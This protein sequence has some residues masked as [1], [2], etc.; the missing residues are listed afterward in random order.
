ME[1]FEWFATTITGLEDLAAEEVEELTNIPAQPDVG[2]IFFRAGIEHALIVNYSSTLVNRVFLLLAR[3][4]IE[5]LD[6][7]YK[8]A[9]GLDYSW[10]IEPSQT[11]AVRAERHDKQLAFTSMDAAATIGRAIIENFKSSM[12][13]RL[14][15]NLDNPDLEFYCLLRGS[16]MFLGLDTTGQSLHR[17]Y[18]RVYAHRAGLQPTI[19]SAMI[20]ISKWR[21]NE[22]LLDPMCGGGTIPI[23]A[24]IRLKNIPCGLMRRE[25]RLEKLKF[26]DQSMV[27]ELRKKIED[28]IDRYATSEIVGSDASPKS[29]EGAR[30]NVE[31]ANVSDTVKLIIGDCLHLEDWLNWEPTHIITNP[32]YGIRVNIR[33][34]AEFYKRFI[35]SVGRAA[36]HS[37]LTVIVSKPRVF[38][39]I[40]EEKNYR[41]QSMREILYGRLRASIIS[42][43]R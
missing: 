41:I 1:Y 12:N 29:I 11:F 25:V 37:K 31:A 18:Y 2:K 39:K 9:K 22:S 42:A 30:R 4:K 26:V 21:K 32:P 35:D 8:V 27:R 10:I 15:V 13:I 7:V 40:L 20:K 28:K 43:E 14:K 24:A 38:T 34:I 5:S 3:E 36:P 33:N 6:D 23:E 17:R 19:A 16:E